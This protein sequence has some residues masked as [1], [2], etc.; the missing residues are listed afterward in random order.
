M[1]K[2][3]WYD[4]SLYDRLIAPNQDPAFALVKS[5]V[6]PGSTLLDV[7]CGTGRLA[8]QLADTCATI[9]AIDPSRRNIAAANRRLV[10]NPN[11]AVHFHHAD[12]S[13]FLEGQPR[14]FDVATMSYVI[15]EI[16]ESERIGILQSLASA[17]KSIILVDFLVPQP[18]RAIHWASTVV[19]FSAGPD[20]FRGFRSFVKGGG[21]AGLVAKSGLQI[22]RDIRGRLPSTQITIVTRPGA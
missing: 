1:N 8:F 3:H 5:L 9:D 21:L 12:L 6:P 10:R 20:H 15:H 17:A 16:H 4:G 7:G 19:E 18:S 22:V 11:D 14:R 13:R 2:N